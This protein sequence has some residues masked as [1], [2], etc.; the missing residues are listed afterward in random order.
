M[1]VIAQRLCID[2]HRHSARVEPSADVDLGLV[3]PDV[4]HLFTAVDHDHLATAMNRLAPRHSEVLELR[5]QEGWSYLQIAERL[6]VPVTTV[7]AL[8]HRA[9]KA[10][11]REYMAASRTTRLAGVPILGALTLRV[12]RIRARLGD[13]AAQQV[14]PVVGTAA[15]GLAAAGLVFAPFNSASPPALAAPAAAAARPT[16]RVDAMPSPFAVTLPATAASAVAATAPAPT[17]AA[18]I[19]A[20][21]PVANAGVAAVYG[22]PAGTSYAEAQ[23]DQQPVQVDVKALDLGVNPVQLVD[24]TLTL[25]T[26]A[27][28]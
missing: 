16:A 12:S 19:A 2:H 7:E 18:P 26:G 22:G 21:K 23:N 3:E 11:K 14:L 13:H 1:T 27:P 15:A 5:E 25:V 4:D 24:D 28:K 10:L 20:P 6:E 8:L 9:R 17:A